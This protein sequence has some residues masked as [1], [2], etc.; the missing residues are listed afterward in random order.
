MSTG[1][2]WDYVDEQMTFP[3]LEALNKYWRQ[4]PPV[5]ILVAGYIGYKAPAPIEEN[6]NQGDMD[7]FIALFQ[8]MGG[9]VK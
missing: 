2:T 5:H 4:H 6:N 9:T 7:E 8:N 1:W 3:R